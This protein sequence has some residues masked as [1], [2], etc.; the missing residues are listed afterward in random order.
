MAADFPCDVFLSHR[1]KDKALA[2]ASSLSASNGERVGVRC[3]ILIWLRQDGLEVWFDE[4]V[5]KPPVP[6]AHRMG[7]G[8]RRSGEGC[9]SSQAFGSDWAVLETGTFRFR[10]PLNQE[11]RFIPQRLNDAPIGGS[12]AQFLYINWRPNPSNQQHYL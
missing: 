9:M 6:L 7:E 1:A 3:R 10:A 5:L 2:R 11:R 12:L 8:G 4:W